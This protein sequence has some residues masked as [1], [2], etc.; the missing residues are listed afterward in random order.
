MVAR[1]TDGVTLTCAKCDQY[2]WFGTDGSH[3]CV[4]TTIFSS[5]PSPRVQLNQLSERFVTYEWTQRACRTVGLIAASEYGARMEKASAD[6]AKLRADYQR[7][8]RPW[9][10]KALDRVSQAQ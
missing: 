2:H 4:L 5:N 8:L 7:Q 10:R 6:I 1:T 3:T 9:W